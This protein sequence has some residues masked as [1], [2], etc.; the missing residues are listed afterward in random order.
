MYISTSVPF[1]ALQYEL[2]PYFHHSQQLKI[3][4]GQSVILTTM[5]LPIPLST[6]DTF[7]SLH[8]LLESA[9][10]PNGLERNVVLQD[11]LMKHSI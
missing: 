6:I 9:E 11:L 1:I 7:L 3:M 4:L 8:A 5:F 2:L 10:G